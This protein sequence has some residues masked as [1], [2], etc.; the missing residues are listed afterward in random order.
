MNLAAMLPRFPRVGFLLQQA[1]PQRQAAAA[2]V[3]EHRTMSRNAIVRLENSPLQL[4]VLQGSLWITRDGC[5]AD[6][7]L[8]AGDVFEQRPGAP[9]L[10]QALEQTQLSIA[11]AG[12]GLQN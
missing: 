9:V 4:R 2:G 5:M 1:H 11:G 7:V 10:V 6:M 8:G 12:V 3:L